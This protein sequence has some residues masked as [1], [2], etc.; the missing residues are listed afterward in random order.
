MTPNPNQH[1]VLYTA[2]NERGSK[3]LRAVTF[4]LSRIGLYSMLQRMH[5]CGWL[6]QWPSPE[7]PRENIY[8]T[9]AEGREALK[10]AEITAVELAA[11]YTRFDQ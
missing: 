2:L 3:E 11:F 1:R 8:Q 7:D 4:G 9:S 6:N 10:R 5:A